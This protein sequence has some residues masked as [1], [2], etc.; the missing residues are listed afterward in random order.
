MTDSSVLAESEGEGRWSA[1][2]TQC[3]CE[4]YLEGGR[5]GKEGGR[6]CTWA[7]QRVSSQGE[8][9]PCH[10]QP[11]QKFTGIRLGDSTTNSKMNFEID[12][13]A[14]CPPLLRTPLTMPL[15]LSSKYGLEF[16]SK[17]ILPKPVTPS[18]G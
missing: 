6:A 12:Q 10:C 2:H 15:S 7:R 1:I 9:L 18:W 3:Q 11:G 5:G 4:I 17:G 16:K 13:P 8:R 14:I